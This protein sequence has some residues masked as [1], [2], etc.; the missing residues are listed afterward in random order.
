MDDNAK[1]T[2]PVIEEQLTVDKDMKTTGS[3]HVRK[4]VEEL[5]TPIEGTLTSESYTIERIPKDQVVEKAPEPM[6][7]EGDRI[8][9]SVVEERVVVEKRLVLVEEIHL[10]KKQES[11]NYR[12]EV[13]LR[14][15]VVEVERK[16]VS[17]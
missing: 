17:E 1:L 3:L 5:S 12:E 15:E 7:H 6:R 13:S 16:T 10:I 4:R 9:I 2:I 8:I 14:K 11:R